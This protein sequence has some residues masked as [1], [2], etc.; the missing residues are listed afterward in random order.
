[1]VPLPGCRAGSTPKASRCPRISQCLHYGIAQF[2][3]TCPPR[4]SWNAGAE[5][6]HWECTWLAS[7]ACAWLF[8][9]AV[10][11]FAVV[12]SAILLSFFALGA[13]GALYA[14]TPEAYPTIIRTTGIGAASGMTRIAGAIAPSIGA[15]VAGGSLSL[16]LAVFAIAYAVAGF[17]AL[18][19]PSE[20]KATVLAD[21]VEVNHCF[22]E[23][24]GIFII[25]DRALTRS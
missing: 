16:P 21:T 6:G 10:T 22:I 5:P 20:T 8:A 18:A 4:G 7:G 23:P 24:A 15:L 2:Q 12:A 1:M 9:L 19:L 3:A 14:Y 17:A 13:W 11:P 25:P